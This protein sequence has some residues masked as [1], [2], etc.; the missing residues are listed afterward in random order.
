MVKDTAALTGEI[1]QDEAY[2]VPVR[3]YH[4]EHM[5]EDHVESCQGDLIIICNALADYAGLLS[6]YLEEEGGNLD[7]CSKY[8]YEY[9]ISRCL[10]IQRSISGQIG[11]DRDAAIEKCRKRHHRKD[12]GI[13]EEAMILSVRKGRN[14]ARKAVQEQASD[15]E[16]E[17]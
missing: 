12:E 4:V 9:H 7:A 2:R 1:A 10:K 11:Y 17:N 3:Y 6:E 14:A 5:K 16:K 8:Q 13:G 15:T